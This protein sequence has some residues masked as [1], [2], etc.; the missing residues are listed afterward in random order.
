MLKDRLFPSEQTEE[1][2]YY[3]A[4]KA[5]K[6]DPNQDFTRLKSRIGLEASVFYAH[7]YFSNQ[8]AYQR[9]RRELDLHAREFNRLN[10][11]V[12]VLVVSPPRAT[13]SRALSEKTA[14]RCSALAMTAGFA[15][16]SHAYL[17]STNVLEGARRLSRIIEEKRAMGRELILVSFS[18]GSAFVRVMLDHL[19]NNEKKHIKGWLNISGLIFGSPRF[20]CSD[21]KSFYQKMNLTLRS[22]SSEQKY[23]QEPLKLGGVKVV[24][25]LGLKS[26]EAMSLNE[27]RYREGLKAW[28]PSDGLVP[29]GPYQ[30][31]TGPVMS[32]NNQ[33]HAVDIGQLGSTYVKIL[34]S[35][36]STVPQ[37]DRALPFEFSGGSEFI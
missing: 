8:K 16:V 33:G 2:N 20:H 35:M 27:L 19:N 29:Y 13:M 3:Q 34:S 17:N 23:F 24:H 9:L 6:L 21:K 26:R 18:Y 31:V 25:L 12:D 28:G 30:K 10:G 1:Q 36:V 11:Q 14:K 32:L 15:H 22:F 37:D 7:L 5:F 4:L